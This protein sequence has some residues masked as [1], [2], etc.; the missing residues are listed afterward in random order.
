MPTRFNKSLD[1]RYVTLT[2]A[3][4]ADIYCIGARHRDG[5][6]LIPETRM[7]FFTT[8]TDFDPQSILGKDITLKTD[9]QFKVSGIVTSVEELGFADTDVLYAAEIRPKHWLTTLGAHNRVY[10]GK[11]TDEI[12]RDVLT[13]VEVDAIR[14]ELSGSSPARD[15]CVQYAESDFAFLSRLLEEEG[16]YYFF[17]YAGDAPTMVLCNSVSAHK[18]AGT[19]SFIK[20][21]TSTGAMDTESIQVWTANGRVSAGKVSLWDYD[22]L[23]SKTKLG[24]TAQASVAAANRKAEAYLNHGH[25]TTADVG[26]AMARREVEA[27][28]AGTKRFT[29]IANHPKLI[30]GAV[31]DFDHPDQAGAN[32]A[33]LVTDTTHYMLCD[34]D[35][36][37]PDIGNTYHPHVERIRYP[38][39]MIFFQSTFEVQPKSVPFRPLRTTPWPEVPGFLTAIVTGKAGEEIDTD[40]HGRIRIQFPWD[41]L[42]ENDERSSCWV[43]VVVPWAGNGWGWQGIPRIGMEVIIQFER[44]N[45]DRPYCTGMVYNDINKPPYTLPADMT[46]VG[47]RTNVSKGGGGFHE[48]TFDDKKDAETIFFQSEKDYKQVIKNNAEIT[49]GLEKKDK[50]SLTQTIQQD[51]TEVIKEGDLT[52]TVA[53]GNRITKVKTDDT[54]TVEGKSTTTITGN[55]LLTVKEGNLEETVTQGDVS[56][57]VD[58]GNQTTKVSQ[59][60]IMVQAVA[61]KITVEAAQSIELK[62]GSSSIKIEPAGITITG[63]TITVDGKAMA[64]VKAPMIGVKGQALVEVAAALIKIG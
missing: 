58:A 43:R 39:K 44:G 18:S 53:K 25:Y 5:L 60:N 11:T 31:F 15:Y 8:K 13:R 56:L 23:K 2:G 35:A 64:E 30:T 49:I 14:S 37:D 17:D 36:T 1:K 3:A 63:T 27:R 7:E 34:P 61:G 24:A 41:R 4:A 51:K 50:G 21:S 38:E 59:G 20:A 52:Q 29:G 6:S 12:V 57:T 33:Y 62:V 54:T 32:G 55:T 16:I 47:L 46:K 26:D 19:I 22:P 48:L 10:Q 45:I 28:V 42:G 9:G 40:A